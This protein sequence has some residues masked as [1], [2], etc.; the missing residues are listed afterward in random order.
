MKTWLVGFGALA[1][2]G[3]GLGEWAEKK[4][5]KALQ[6]ELKKESEK[7]AKDDDKEAKADKD[8]SKSDD[9]ADAEMWTEPVTGSKKKLVRVELDAGG[10]A[11]MSML[12]PEGAEVK[13]ALGGSGADVSESGYGFFVWVTE[14]PTATMDLM[15][16]GAAAFFKDSKLENVDDNSFIVVAKGL[17]GESMYLYRGLFKADGKTYR[18]ET[19]SSTAPS[20]KSH[21]EAIDKVCESLE[22]GGKSMASKGAAPADKAEEKAEE[23]VAEADAAAGATDNA[24]TKPASQSAPSKPA[25]Q[26]QAEAPKHEAPKPEAP[27]AEPK[28][29]EP[30][31]APE[32]AKGG[33]K[34]RVSGKGLAPKKK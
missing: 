31:P 9:A 22:K 14:D 12:A 7:N 27:K 34:G 16:Q 6:D 23:K 11:G 24:P 30:A 18:C 8:K 1:L 32:P 25:E 28:K 2:M 33:D 10:L 19:Q 5:N 20:A 21:A 15:K 3:C 17:D 29:P 4:A 26:K 13:K